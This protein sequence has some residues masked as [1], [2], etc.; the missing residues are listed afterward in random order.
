[1]GYIPLR[2]L[3]KLCH[4]KREK[5]ISLCKEHK[6]SFLIKEPEEFIKEKSSYQVDSGAFICWREKELNQELKRYEKYLKKENVPDKS[7]F[8]K[9]LN[10]KEWCI[11]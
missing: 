9:T 11:D 1:M 2:T 10:L 6:I 3:E 5:V 8:D 7:E 4:V